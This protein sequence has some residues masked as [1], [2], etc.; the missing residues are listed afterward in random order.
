MKAFANFRR[1]SN[2]CSTSKCEKFT[3]TEGLVCTSILEEK[4][5]IQRLLDILQP[6]SEEHEIIKILE[7]INSNEE[8]EFVNYILHN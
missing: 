3:D 8:Q 1:V 7:E 2:F 5:S 6:V 4:E